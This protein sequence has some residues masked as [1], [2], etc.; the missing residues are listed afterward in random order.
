[1]AQPHSQGLSSSLP[2]EQERRGRGEALGTRLVM[3]IES[4]GKAS[5]DQGHMHT[6]LLRK[7]GTKLFL[8]PNH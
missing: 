1:M 6:R 8:C 5:F 2:L 4:P 7:M 3:T